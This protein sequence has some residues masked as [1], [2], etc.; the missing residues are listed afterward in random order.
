VAYIY[1]VLIGAFH[2]PFDVVDEASVNKRSD[3]LVRLSICHLSLITD[4]FLVTPDIPTQPAPVHIFDSSPIE[5]LPLDRRERK[6]FSW[7]DLSGGVYVLT[8]FTSVFNI[9]LVDR[10]S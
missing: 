5:M 10:Y 4:L 1:S 6:G 2:P 3:H 7:M 9:P 8:I